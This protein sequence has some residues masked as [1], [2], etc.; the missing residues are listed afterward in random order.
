M[1]DCILMDYNSQL[2]INI[3]NF[4]SRMYLK[5]FSMSEQ[6]IQDIQHILYRNT[7]SY[8]MYISMYNTIFGFIDIFLGG[9]QDGK[10]YMYTIDLKRTM[11]L[12]PHIYLY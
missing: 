6:H 2:V 4:E 3:L 1:E 11:A 9:K 7:G 12:L 8:N 5:Q 10:Q